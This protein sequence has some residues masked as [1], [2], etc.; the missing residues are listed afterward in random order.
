[1]T[2]EKADQRGRKQQAVAA[3]RH[4]RAFL[5]ACRREGMDDVTLLTALGVNVGKLLVEE[6][7]QHARL[8]VSGLDSQVRQ[9]LQLLEQEPS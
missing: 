4:W 2:D 6:Y 5:T 8:W 1:M 7:P 9:E 3:L